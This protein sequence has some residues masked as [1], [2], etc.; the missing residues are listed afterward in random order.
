MHLLIFS[1]STVVYTFE[2]CN[3]SA[4]SKIQNCTHQLFLKTPVLNLISYKR[5]CTFS[6]GNHCSSITTTFLCVPKQSTWTMASYKA[7]DTSMSSLSLYVHF[8]QLLISLLLYDLLGILFQTIGI[9]LFYK[10]SKIII[11]DSQR[12]RYR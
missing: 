8:F 6:I 9:K 5:V 7:L 12:S 1:N 2:G 11:S 10:D 3:Y 4:K